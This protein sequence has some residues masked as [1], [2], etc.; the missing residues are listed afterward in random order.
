MLDRF[1]DSFSTSVKLI[2]PELRVKFDNSVI[3]SA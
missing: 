3:K 1:T 2:S